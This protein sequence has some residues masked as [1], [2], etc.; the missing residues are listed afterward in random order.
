[1]LL[2][3]ERMANSSLVSLPPD[4][5]EET[6]LRRTLSLIIEQLDIVVG[7]KNEQSATTSATI[8]EL[9]QQNTELKARIERLEFNLKKEINEVKTELFFATKES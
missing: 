4:L 5:S 3:E 1:M 7:N 8:A 2:G 9:R 6:T